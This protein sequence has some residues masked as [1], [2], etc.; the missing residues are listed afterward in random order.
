MDQDEINVE[1]AYRRYEL[2]KVKGD[3]IRLK[4]ESAD[5]DSRWLSITRRDLDAVTSALMNFDPD[6]WKD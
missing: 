6:D 3:R 5:G 2:G 4:V 1:M